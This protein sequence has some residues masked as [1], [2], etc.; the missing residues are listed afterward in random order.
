MNGFVRTVSGNVPSDWIDVNGHMN[1]MWYTYLFNE[2]NFALMERIGITDERVDQGYPTI[3]GSRLL[4][5]HRGALFLDDPF[6][7][8]SGFITVEKRYLTVTHRIFTESQLKATC[9]IRARAYIPRERLTSEFSEEILQEAK[10]IIVA[11][12]KDPFSNQSY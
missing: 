1:I 2:G 10:K 3:V 12:L 5:E 8:W 7:V 11:G 6:E 9:S 4:V